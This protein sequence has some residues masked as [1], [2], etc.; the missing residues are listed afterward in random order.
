M[1]K[2]VGSML[3]YLTGK[4][5]VLGITCVFAFV[6]AICLAC[7][8]KGMAEGLSS[9]NM[10]ERWSEENDA[11]QISCFFSQKVTFG[12][13]EIQAFRHYL[14]SALVAAAITNDSENPS[15]RLWAD[16]YSGTGVVTL[17]SDRASVSVDAVGVGGDFFLFHPLKLVSG[18]Y[19]SEG[20]VMK[21]YCVVDEETAWQLFGSNDIAGQVITIQDVPHIIVGVIKREQGRLA[22]AAGLDEPL[23]YVSYETLSS[24][25]QASGISC[26]ELVMPN[27]VKGYTLDYVKS[28]IGTSQTETLVLENTT[29]YGLLSLL[30]VLGGFGTRSMNGMAVIYPYWE[31]IARGYEDLL[32]LLLLLQSILL[33]YGGILILI[34]LIT[35]WRHKTWTA[36]SV[37]LAIK[38][39]LQDLREIRW[40]KKKK[41]REV[42]E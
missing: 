22:K 38:N 6:C 20:D 30:N 28:N 2:I 14:D 34:A 41:V 13:E 18:Y 27:P 5:L 15:A 33:L 8:S 23:V 4:R 37:W 3:Q 10:A 25:G 17:T 19:F 31:N 29:R 21:D 36:R 11:A 26:Y 16:A 35:A 32:A 7:I 24:Y 39:K 12:E 9:Q 40:A 1:K 42:K